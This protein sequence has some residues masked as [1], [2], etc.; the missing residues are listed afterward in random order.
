MQL[1]F[2]DIAV[3]GVGS[4]VGLVFFSMVLRTVMRLFEETKKEQ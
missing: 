3:I 4:G 2:V 1:E